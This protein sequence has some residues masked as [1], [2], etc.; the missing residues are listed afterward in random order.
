LDSSYRIFLSFRSGII[1][2]KKALLIF[3]Y[4]VFTRNMHE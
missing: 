1:I 4:F 3:K 2:C